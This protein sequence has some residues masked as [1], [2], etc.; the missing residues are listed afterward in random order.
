MG[1]YA[2]QGFADMGNSFLKSYKGELDRLEQQRRYDQEQAWKDEQRGRQRQDWQREDDFNRVIQEEYAPVEPTVEPGAGDKGPAQAFQVRGKQFQTRDAADQYAASENAPTR[3]LMRAADRGMAIDPTRATKLRNDAMTSR[4]AELQ[5]SKAE[6]DQADEIYNRQIL[7]MLDVAPNWWDGAAK[8]GE[9]MLKG[10]GQAGAELSPD[11]KTV[12][13]FAVDA[14]GKRTERG[15]FPANAQG[16]EMYLQSALKTNTAGKMAFI[17]SVADAEREYDKR[18]QIRAEGLEDNEVRLKQEEGSAIRR[19]NATTGSR[20]AREPQG[21]ITTVMTP[22]GKPTYARAVGN[23]LLPLD[24]GGMTLPPKEAPRFD[25]KAYADTFKSFVESG[26]SAPN[27]RIEADRLFGRLPPEQ[28]G[29]K[30]ATLQATNAARAGKGGSAPEAASP[31]PHQPSKP[32]PTIAEAIS[33]P[34]SS[35]ALVAQFE[36]RARLVQAAAGRVKAAQ[37]AV[38]R[39]A[40]SGDQ[41]A[42]QAAMAEVPIAVR[43]VRELVKGMNPQQAAQVIKAAGL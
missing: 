7:G 43:E 2:F 3:R 22:D 4:A 27:A 16:R 5:L 21:S 28:G 6:Q 29:G 34:G 1:P 32:Q 39:A 33:G 41:A 42:V 10:N 24:M 30:D 37:A 19:Y 12:R 36:K 9:L 23:K 17:T 40:Q 35:P 20:A 25:P 11:G 38:V 15:E 14:E 26:M 13:L 31:P 18:Q 8:I